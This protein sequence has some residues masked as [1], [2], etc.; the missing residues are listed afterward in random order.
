MGAYEVTAL[1]AGGVDYGESDRVVHLITAH[2][3][4]DAFAHG[5]KKSK[6]R[7]A[8]ALEPFHTISAELTESRRTKD[9]LPTLSSASIHKVRLGIR[10]ELARIALASYV[11]ELSLRTCPAGEACLSQFELTASALDALDT[12]PA[13]RALRRAFELRLLAELGYEPQLECCL[14]CGQVPDRTYL[15]LQ[16]GGVL[17]ALHRGAAKEVGPKTLQWARQVLQAE[18]LDALGG[19]DPEWAQT[20][21]LKLTEPLSLA[22]QQVLDRPLNALGL[23]ETVQL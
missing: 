9:G 20:A 17:C 4:V 18:G 8:G 16:R 6:R 22:W 3:R 7:F 21:A 23:L 13:T 1:V 19:C 14:Q 15:D 11:V 10:S 2:G 12:G 5:A